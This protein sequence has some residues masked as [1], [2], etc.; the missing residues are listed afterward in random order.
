MK[1]YDDDPKNGQSCSTGAWACPANY[2]WGTIVIM[3]L[4]FFIA[5]WI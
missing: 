5:S 3:L 2:I 4:L 1:I